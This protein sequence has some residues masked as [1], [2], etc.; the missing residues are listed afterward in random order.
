MISVPSI[1]IIYYFTTFWNYLVGV[2]PE[3]VQFIKSAFGLMVGL[4]IPVSMA[5]LIGIVYCVETIKHIRRREEAIYSPKKV[6]PAFTD[7]DDGKES[8]IE[9]ANRWKKIMQHMENGSQND[10]KQA[11]IEAD[12]ILDDLL[13]KLGY[14]GESIGEKLKR[15]AKGDFKSLDQAWEAHKIRNAIAHDGSTFELNQIEA[16]RVI[17]LYRKVLEEFYH[18]S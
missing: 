17:G 14:K 7:I 8:D 18:I 1:D 13:N 9:T 15:V 3:F 11:I 6:E 16:Q 2:F 12:V 4:S 10:W 5:L